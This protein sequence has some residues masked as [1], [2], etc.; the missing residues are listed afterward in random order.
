MCMCTYVY[1]KVLL[2]PHAMVCAV[3]TQTS[4]KN[5]EWAL[6]LGMTGTSTVQW[7]GLCSL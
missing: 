4:S 3:F 7:T 2:S 5:A 1:M 6:G